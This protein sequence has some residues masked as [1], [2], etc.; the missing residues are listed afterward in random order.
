MKPEQPIADSVPPSL[1][2]VL[3]AHGLAPGSEQVHQLDRYRELLWSWNEKLNLTRHT[4]LE[5]FVTRDVI[6]SD[7]LAT[8]L[9]RR[10]R[11]LDVGT[12]GGVPGVILAILRPDLRVSLCESTGK[13]ARAVEAI[14]QDMGLKLP[15]FHTRAEEVLEVRTFDT[16]VVRAVAPLAKLL[17]WS[18]GSWK[19][20]DRLLVIK[21]RSWPEERGEA[22]HLGLLRNLDLRI[23]AKYRTPDTGAESVILQIAPKGKLPLEE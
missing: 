7:Q 16:L 10:E 1:A 18:A 9:A 2:D 19:A 14:V 4:T 8:L 23:A 3:A 22:R 15:V 13:K 6:D 21:G 17:K 11:V 5:K 12:G 20:F